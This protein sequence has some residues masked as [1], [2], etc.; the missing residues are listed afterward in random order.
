MSSLPPLPRAWS[1][2]TVE[3][4]AAKEPNAIT[5]GPF[6]SNLKREHYTSSGPRVIRLQNIGNAEFIDARSHISEEHFATL[7]KHRVQ[8]GDVVIA[9]L[10]NALPRACV[11][12][13]GLGPAI[14]KADCIRLKVAAE[15]DPRYVSYALT[16]ESTRRRV[17]AIVHGVG[18]PRLN[19][20]EIR[21][22]PPPMAPPKEQREIVEEIEKQLSRLD[23]GVAA[24]KR[25]QDN[26]KRYRAA[27]LK[28]ACEGRLVP[29]EAEIA[30]REGRPYEP[31][32]VLLERIKAE[33]GQTESTTQPRRVRTRT[34]AIEP[35]VL[36]ALPE[37]WVW[38][39]LGDS[40]RR[41]SYGTSIK[42][43]PGFDGPLVARIPNVQSGTFDFTNIKYAPS[44][45]QLSD[46]ES[47]RPGDMLIIRTNGSKSLLGRCAIVHGLMEPA[48]FASYLIRFRLCGTEVLWAWLGVVWQAGSL[49]T[50]IEA[51]AASS[52]GQHNISMSVL[53]LAPI[54][55]P[56]H[57]EQQRIVPEVGRRLSLADGLDRIVASNLQRAA[58]LRQS[59]L[60]AAFG[61]QLPGIASGG[62]YPAEAAGIAR[63]AEGAPTY[64]GGGDLT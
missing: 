8:P 64:P 44:S 39:T 53:S 51:R 3:E 62:T 17:R 11:L 47:L 40:A 48:T 35:G 33:R 49:R 55:V 24:L 52:A 54:P 15:H 38:S 20:R 57:A 5:D 37:G 13:H 18:R 42:C 2:K 9:S 6:G 26:L 60:A 29:T 12:P 32:S 45:F 28:A 58:L 59:I 43:S 14:V 63:A 21:S 4:L 16:C 41:A 50:W 23:A 19:L 61:G 1:W 34:P 27:V 25:I 46:A 36:P 22:I 31:A 10:G 56:P 30:R 7:S